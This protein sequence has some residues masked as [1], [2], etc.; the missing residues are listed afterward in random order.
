MSATL[1]LLK[2]G[3]L[4]EPRSEAVD[5]PELGGSVVVRGLM[6]S[7]LFAITSMRSQALKSV[8]KA[9]AEH[10]EACK[11]IGPGKPHPPFEAPELSF[12][13]LKGY[14]QYVSQLLA[15]T[16]TVGNG[17]ALFTAEQWEVAGQHHPGLPQRLQLVA[18]R[19]SGLDAE[20]VEKNSPKTQS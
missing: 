3:P 14:G 20:D 1:P 8:R 15:S 2:A 19:L 12:Q 4:L 16:V 10:A 11:A 9:R 7:E 5:V 13:E 18:E 6:A 17:L